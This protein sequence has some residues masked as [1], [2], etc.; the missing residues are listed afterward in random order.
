MWF[1]KHMANAGKGINEN[2][3]SQH[4]AEEFER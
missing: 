4:F 3:V 1:T 2:D